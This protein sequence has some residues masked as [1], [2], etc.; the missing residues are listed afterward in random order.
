MQQEADAA[1]NVAPAPHGIA[2]PDYTRRAITEALR[3][4]PVPYILM[5]RP[6]T[7]VSLA[8]HTIPKGA[9]VLYSAYALQRD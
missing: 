2:Q 7:D 6:N 3:M 8:G 1:H 9:I 4:Y 5:R